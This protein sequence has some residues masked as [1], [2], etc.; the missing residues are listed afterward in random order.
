MT[1]TRAHF[2]TSPLALRFTDP[3]RQAHAR[4]F[5]DQ[6][7]T[8]AT[9]AR[10][11]LTDLWAV[12]QHRADRVAALSA[13]HADLIAWRYDLAVAAGG[14]LGQGIAHTPQRFRTPI[15][16]GN[17]NYDRVGRVGR[18]CEG[19]EWD[20]ASRTY[21][22][23]TPTPAAEAMLKYGRAAEARFDEER[24]H[25]DVLQNWVTLPDGRRISGNR[26]V[27]GEAAK[28][29]AEELT[30]RVAARG[31]DVS[32][33]ETGG[34]PIY[35]ATPTAQDSKALFAAALEI[36]ADPDLTP[37]TYLTARYCL[38]QAPQT[39]KG[40][41]AVS[42]TFIVAVGALALGDAAPALPADI[43]LRCYVLG[44]AAATAA[45]ASPVLD[46]GE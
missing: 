33:M 8:A 7:A 3:D 44:Q 14:R 39:K 42:R 4:A 38:F 45:H 26:I 11:R 35:T 43:D 6:Q 13:V 19:A 1:I 20:P 16:E 5:A 12:S 15:S 17:I 32:R 40:S 37:E 18:L 36:L 23:G 2:P 41:D 46:E 22:G 24:E 29:I 31:I 21:V 28:G 27:R 9:A 34:I 10:D 25:G 30:A